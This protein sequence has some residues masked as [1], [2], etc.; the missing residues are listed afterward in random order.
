MSVKAILLTVA[1]L[2]L[3]GLGAIGLLVPIWPTTPFMIGAAACFSG[4][5]KLQ[6]KLK[7]LPVFGEHIENY[8]NRQGL[9]RKTVLFSLV[10]LWGMLALSWF[11]LRTFW[12]IALLLLIGV[13]VT[14]HVLCM[15]RP[16]RCT[17]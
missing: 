17:S 4:T 15:A 7:R 14:V 2:L 13:A 12:V 16:R 6:A 11:F 10:F 5:P 9:S 8:Q 3:L 1:G